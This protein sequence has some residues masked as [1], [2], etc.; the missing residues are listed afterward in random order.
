[1]VLLLG[2]GSA[3]CPPAQRLPAPAGRHTSPLQ[4]YH[5]QAGP[6]AGRR[7][8][9]RR[10][11]GRQPFESSAHPQLARPA[12]LVV[13]AADLQGRPAPGGDPGGPLPAGR[14]VPAGGSE[15]ADSRSLS[16]WPWCWTTPPARRGAAR[17][18][19]APGAGPWPETS[20]RLHASEFGGFAKTASSCRLRPPPRASPGDLYDF[21]KLPDGPLSFFVGTYPGKECRRPCSMVAVRTLSRHPGRGGR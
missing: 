17:G 12:L 10:R 20:S 19:P 18:A 9:Q 14:S 13:R 11:P 4:P 16:R 8:A 2:V 5:R 1:M 7:P 3:W 6:G 21:L 15:P